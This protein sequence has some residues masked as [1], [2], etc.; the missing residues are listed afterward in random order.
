[1]LDDI[2]LYWFTQTVAFAARYY[3]E[4][5]RGYTGLP[6]ESFFSAGRIELPMA[7]TVFPCEFYRAPRAWA[8]ASWPNLLYWNEVEKGGHFAAFE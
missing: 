8:E 5:G 1:M 4:N 3:W 7:G 2:S 6:A